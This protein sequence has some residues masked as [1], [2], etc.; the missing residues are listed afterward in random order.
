MMQIART[1][2]MIAYFL[3]RCSNSSPLAGGAVV[4]SAG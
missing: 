4:I 3:R 2:I 1:A